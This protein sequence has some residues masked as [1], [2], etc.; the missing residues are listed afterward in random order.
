MFRPKINFDADYE[1]LIADYPPESNQEVYSIYK[2]MEALL[3]KEFN[4]S[5][6]TVHVF[7]HNYIEPRLDIKLYRRYVDMS[8]MTTYKYD[9]K[10]SEDK[11]RYCRILHF[12]NVL[13]PELTYKIYN[14]FGNI[15]REIVKFYKNQL[16]EKKNEE[17][18]LSIITN[19]AQERR[20]KICDIEFH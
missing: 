7:I 12:N 20:T 15:N 5:K 10:K 1:R 13:G 11:P 6:S 14:Q 19:K 3:Q 17:N 2:S 18:N 16:K 4:Y 8:P 9:F